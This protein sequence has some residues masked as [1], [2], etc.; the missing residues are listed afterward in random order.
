M[1][2]LATDHAYRVA[3]VVDLHRLA[4]M[5]HLAHR[6]AASRCLLPF[7]QPQLELA[8]LK[9]VRMVGLA[10]QPQQLARECLWRRNS[11]SIAD[12]SGITRT[13]AGAG[14]NSAASSAASD[15]PAAAARAR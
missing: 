6:Q 7:T 3:G 9:A 11:W 15:S 13:V 12:Q 1:R 2:G 10:L 8:E 14:G 4:G 5:M